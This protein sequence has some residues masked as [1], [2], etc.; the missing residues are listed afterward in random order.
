VV[1]YRIA[2]DVWYSYGSRYIDEFS[3]KQLSLHTKPFQLTNPLTWA[4]F[5]THTG[6]HAVSAR[7]IATSYLFLHSPHTTNFSRRAFSFTAPTLWNQLP[8]S[9]LLVS[10]SPTLYIGLH[11]SIV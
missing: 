4:V 8:T 9:R 3:L 6:H 2:Y 1:A 7:Q 11:S 5:Y 10:G